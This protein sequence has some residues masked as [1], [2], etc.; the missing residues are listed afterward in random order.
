MFDYLKNIPIWFFLVCAIETHAESTG[1]YYGGEARARYE[2]LDGQFRSG[3]SGNDQLGAF[4]GLVSLGYQGQT[5]GF[6]AELQDARGYLNDSSS[7]TSPSFVNPLD[8][9]QVYGSLRL[10]QR[11][12]LADSNVKLGRFTLDIGSRRFV[13]RNDFRNTI[14]SYTGVHWNSSSHNGSNLDLFFVSPVDKKPKD[15]LSLSENKLELDKENDNKRFWGAHWQRPDLFNE[16]QLDIF[17]Y[18]VNEFDR[19]AKLTLDREVIT[20]G[21]RVLRKKKAGRFDLDV[22]VGWRR[23]EMSQSTDPTSPELK[24]R[25]HMIHAEI[26]YTFSSSWNP[27]LGLEFD[28]ATGDDTDT[29]YRYERYERF[30]GTRRG[31]LGNTSIHGPLT[32]SNISVPGLRF[33]FKKGPTDGRFLLQRASLHS[34]KDEWVV[35]KLRNE[36][37]DTGSRLGNTFDFRIR[38]WLKEDHVRIEIGGS[39]LEFSHYVKELKPNLKEDRTIYGYSQI[40]WFF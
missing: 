13:E 24:V 11:I 29:I 7:P 35:A 37:G 1:F 3:R 16:V 10:P 9:L 18:G 28:L 17:V 38:H 5:M 23:G 19:P 4:R 15:F 26:G 40:S 22:E 20:A 6:H 2:S 39:I 12:L 14:N 34:A 32:R 30:Y 31:D 36:T 8:L 25:A 27:R 33:S 21:T